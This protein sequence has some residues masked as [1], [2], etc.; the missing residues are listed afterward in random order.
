MS[1]GNN[2]VPG[3]IVD[4]VSTPGAFD[5]YLVSHH[6]LQ[7]TARPVR[8]VI[9]KNDSKFTAMQLYESVYALCHLYARAT[10]SVSVVPPIYYAH[11]GAARGKC[12]L[13]KNKDGVFN[14]RA[15]DK[16]IQKTLYYL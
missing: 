12:Y 7:G 3:T 5:F 6:A 14:M 13:E 4:E 1:N 16:D 15:C 10:K 9:V 2:L 11:L 8:Y